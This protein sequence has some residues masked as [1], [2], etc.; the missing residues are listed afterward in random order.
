[1][2]GDIYIGSRIFII[3]IV[4]FEI[5]VFAYGPI[6]KFIEENLTSSISIDF[7]PGL[8]RVSHIYAPRFKLRFSADE[9][10]IGNPSILIGVYTLEC[11]PVLIVLSE[12]FE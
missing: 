2:R 4:V 5:Q 12:K 6:A 11:H 9:L 1:V 8:L 10:L 3:I 7:F